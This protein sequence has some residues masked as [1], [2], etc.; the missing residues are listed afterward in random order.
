MVLGAD[1]IYTERREVIDALVTT[2]IVPI[3]GVTVF[4]CVEHRPESVSYFEARRT[5]GRVYVRRRGPRA[6]RPGYG[7]EG[8]GRSGGGDDARG[9]RGAS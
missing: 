3:G 7:R 6:L 9:R 2:S 4:A 1:L 5:R 8:A